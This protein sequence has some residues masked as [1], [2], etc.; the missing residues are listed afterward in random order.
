[1]QYDEKLLQDA[2]DFANKTVGF[3]ADDEDVPDVEIVRA[4]LIDGFRD[5]T[6]DTGWIGLA[7]GYVLL[8]GPG[9]TP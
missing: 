4:A 9:A 1:M 5:G 2:A 3:A 7:V 8:R 6:Y